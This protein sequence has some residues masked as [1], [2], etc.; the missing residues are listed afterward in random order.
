M[1]KHSKESEKDKNNGRNNGG[2][3]KD[4][5][6]KGINDQNQNKGSKHKKIR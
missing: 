2:Q 1:L 6:K 4:K 3:C 5:H